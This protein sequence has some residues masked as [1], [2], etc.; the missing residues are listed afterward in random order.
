MT[1]GGKTDEAAYYRLLLYLEKGEGGRTEDGSD[2][3]RGKRWGK[4]RETRH[5]V[6]KEDKDLEAK[7]ET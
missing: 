5:E 7:G 2:G 3:F 6:G 4:I 1:R